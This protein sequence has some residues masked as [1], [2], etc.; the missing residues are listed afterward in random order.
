LRKKFF[1]GKVGFAQ[2]MQWTFSILVLCPD[3]DNLIEFDN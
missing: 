2:M 1:F 3:C